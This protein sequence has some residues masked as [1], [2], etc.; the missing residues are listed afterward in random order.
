MGRDEGTAFLVHRFQGCF[1]PHSCPPPALESQGQCELRGVSSGI[2]QGI[3]EA[4][5][6]VGSEGGWAC[7]AK[8]E[9]WSEVEG[10]LRGR[11]VL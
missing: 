4:R 5:K 6:N 3:T 8:G 9:A 1:S 2:K 11:R 10:R 7:G